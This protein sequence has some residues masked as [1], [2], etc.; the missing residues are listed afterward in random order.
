MKYKKILEKNL[1]I[2]FFSYV[3][4]VL[5]SSFAV[6]IT[7]IYSTVTLNTHIPQNN[8]GSFINHVVKLSI[9]CIIV[10]VCLF[11]VY[12]YS[13]YIKWRTEEFKTF[14]LIGVTKSELRLL[15]KIES[16]V[17][18]TTA[19]IVGTFFGIIFSKL[20]FLSI[21]KLCGL[22]NIPFEITYRNYLSVI[23]LFL[24]MLVTMVEKSYRLSK[25]FDAKDILKYRNKPI[26]IKNENNKI[27]VFAFIIVACIVYKYM[28]KSFIKSTE[29]YVTNVFVS[30]IIAYAAS[31]PIAFIVREMIKKNKK[32]RYLQIKSVRTILDMDK[33]ITFLL[34]FFSFMIISYVR[35]NYVYSIKYKRMLDVF[36]IDFTTFIYVFTLIL[37]FIIF[38]II[39]FYKTS[40]NVRAIKKLYHK[41]FIIGITQ[42]EFQKFIKFKLLITFFK[43]FVLSLFMSIIY[44]VISNLEFVFSFKTVLIYLVYFIFLMLGYFIANKKYEEE[45]FK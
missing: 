14:I 13:N 7:F 33:K 17:L 37:C 24:W 12:S 21:L 45:I 6:M 36:K 16:F 5:S 39:I 43:P 38:S 10:S 22:K 23:L 34:A 40:S 11:I 9:L 3:G 26:F 18:F 31:S 35:I 30:M 8:E 44:I 1:R 20:F 32:N 42:G 15:V 19:L 4:F 41:L 25:V 28:C 27:K 2:N 29:F